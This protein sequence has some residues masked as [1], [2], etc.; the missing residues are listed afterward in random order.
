MNFRNF[1]V[2]FIE[3]RAQTKNTEITENL[4]PWVWEVQANVDLFFDHCFIFFNAK[5]EINKDELNLINLDG[6]DALKRQICGT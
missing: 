6:L 4:Y 2:F 3:Y 5:T 1:R